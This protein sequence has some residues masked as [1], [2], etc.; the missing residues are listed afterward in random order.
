MVKHKRQDR[1]SPLLVYFLRLP[2]R[3]RARVHFL[4]LQLKHWRL[5]KG[6]L[7]DWL[8]DSIF[9]VP[10][11]SFFC[12]SL[13]WFPIKHNGTAAGDIYFELTFYAAVRI[14]PQHPN[15]PCSTTTMSFFKE[16]IHFITRQRI[17]QAQPVLCLER[18]NKNGVKRTTARKIVITSKLRLSRLLKRFPY[19]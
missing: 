14:T 9:F 8:T 19:H 12:P 7:M 15:Q 13:V 4:P 18:T 2:G 16:S 6:I 1:L 17:P 11:S 5:Y 3:N 10:F